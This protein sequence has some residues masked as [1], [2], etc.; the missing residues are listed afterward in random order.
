MRNWASSPPFH[1]YSMPTLT[2][3][4]S[5]KITQV[6]LGEG[7]RNSL[8]GGGVTCQG[9]SDLAFCSPDW[10]SRCKQIMKLWR[11]VPAADKAPYLVRQRGPA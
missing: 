3:L 9:S 11:K 2:F 4:I 5:S 7:Q 10:S 6:P 8:A 1:L